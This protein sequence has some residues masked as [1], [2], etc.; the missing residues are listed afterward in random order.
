M[1]KS[2]VLERVSLDRWRLTLSGVRYMSEME[3]AGACFRLVV[4]M[5][6]VQC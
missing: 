4:K 2:T 5:I 1:M 6:E 3:L